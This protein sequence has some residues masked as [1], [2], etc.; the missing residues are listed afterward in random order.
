M[1][2]DAEGGVWTALFGTGEVHRYTPE[3]R[4]DRFRCRHGR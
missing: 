2:V 1:T 3:G 4:L